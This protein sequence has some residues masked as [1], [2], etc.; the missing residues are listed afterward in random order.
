VDHGSE[1]GHGRREAMSVEADMIRE[2]RRAPER[3]MSGPEGARPQS[4]ARVLRGGPEQ[5]DGSTLQS[6]ASAEN[7]S[8]MDQT[9][10]S[11]QPNDSSACSTPALNERLYMPPSLE[12]R[13]SPYALLG[14][15]LNLPFNADTALVKSARMAPPGKG[16]EKQILH[17]ILPSSKGGLDHKNALPREAWW[18]CN[19]SEFFNVVASRAGRPEGSFSCL[20]LTYNWAVTESFVVNKFEGDQYWEE[21]RQRVKAKFLKARNSMKKKI[22]KFELWVECGDTTNIDEVDEEDDC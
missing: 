18:G 5:N 3:P 7:S 6:S 10:S 19:L 9:L 8:N 4:R 11:L 13:S 2:P 14:S 1:V 22:P 15:S 17:Y 20:T 12:K 16:P 21:I